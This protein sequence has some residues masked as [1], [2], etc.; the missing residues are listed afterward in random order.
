MESFWLAETLKYFYLL[1]SP[2]DM[3]PLTDVVFNTE[4][5]PFPRF[6]LGKLFKTGWERKARDAE[7]KLVQETQKHEGAPAVLDGMGPQKIETIHLTETRAVATS[8]LA[9]VEMTATTTAEGAYTASAE[10]TMLAT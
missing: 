6:Q 8:T 7:G 2:N 3:L 10:S 1:F 9:D 5:H 4:A